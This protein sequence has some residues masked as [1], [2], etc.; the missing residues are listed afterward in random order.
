MEYFKSNQL[1]EL[2]TTSLSTAKIVPDAAAPKGVKFENVSSEGGAS[3]DIDFLHIDDQDQSVKED[4]AKIA[5]HPLVAPGIPV[6]GYVYD[7][8]TGKIN[9]IVSAVTRQ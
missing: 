4:V 7:C 1:A 5:Q 3:T 6:H 9:H 8:K 2:L